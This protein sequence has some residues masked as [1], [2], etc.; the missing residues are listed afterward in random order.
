VTVIGRFCD[1]LYICYNFV[2]H[3]GDDRWASREVALDNVYSD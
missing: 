2:F 3:V 1:E